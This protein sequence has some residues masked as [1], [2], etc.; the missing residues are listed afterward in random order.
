MSVKFSLRFE[1]PTPEDHDDYATAA[2]RVVH[3]VARQLSEYKTGGNVRDVNGNTIG[4]WKL[5]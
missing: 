2:S 4:S 1:L 5:R 3:S